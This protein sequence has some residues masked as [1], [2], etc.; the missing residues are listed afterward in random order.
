MLGVYHVYN[1]WHISDKNIDDI[2]LFKEC[3]NKVYL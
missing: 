2:I 3:I 1:S